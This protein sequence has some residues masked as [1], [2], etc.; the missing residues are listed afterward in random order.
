MQITKNHERHWSC[1]YPGCKVTFTSTVD[2]ND[3]Y[4][5][6]KHRHERH[7]LMNKIRYHVKK[8]SST[9]YR[10]KRVET[11]KKQIVK[12]QRI[13]QDII[14]TLQIHRG[15]LDSMVTELDLLATLGSR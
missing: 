5:C 4:Y 15:K 3:K 2:H 14:R 1:A 8:N 11:L 10:R 7:R 12:Q 13:E 9:Y 6:K